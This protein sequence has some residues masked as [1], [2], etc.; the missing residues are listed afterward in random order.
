[1]TA[2]Q[3]ERQARNHYKEWKRSGDYALDSVYGSYSANKARAWRYC[4]EKAIELNGRGLKVITHNSQ[5]FTVGFEYCDEK[6]GT[7]KFYYITPSYDC[8][9][10]ITADML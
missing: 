5:I 7:A 3:M 9:I 1:M 4:Q 6:T 8:T 10:D 2:K